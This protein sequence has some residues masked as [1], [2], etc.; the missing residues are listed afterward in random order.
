MEMVIVGML[1]LI[2]GLVCFMINR[3]YWKGDHKGDY[4][5]ID[6][7]QSMQKLDVKDGDTVVLTYPGKLTRDTYENV[8][9]AVEKIIKEFGFNVHVMILEEG[10]QIGLLRKEN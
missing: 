7:I 9:E 3:G 4:D 1:G 5:G 2:L 8:K 10:M 6:C